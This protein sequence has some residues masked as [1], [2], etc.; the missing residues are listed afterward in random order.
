MQVTTK[1]G[2]TRLAKTPTAKEITDFL[3]DVEEAVQQMKC[4]PG[5]QPSSDKP[6]PPDFVPL[7]SLDNAAVH[8]K[9]IEDYV[10]Q[11][12]DP[13]MARFRFSC[14][15]P[16]YSPDL[17]KVIEHVHG[18]VCTAFNKQ[19]QDLKAEPKS[20]VQLYNKL[21]D[22]FY[23]MTTAASVQ[24]DVDSLQETFKQVIDLEGAFP[25]AK[26]R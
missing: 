9:A 1:A 15:P 21:E 18:T 25:P 20:I 10:K 11:S 17:H 23:S 4:K 3:S 26:Y 19:L 14:S 16:P 7:I 13:T 8:V 24:K 2:V 12:A 6:F 22:I 5:E